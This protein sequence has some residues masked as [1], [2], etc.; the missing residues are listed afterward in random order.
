[1]RVHSNSLFPSNCYDVSLPS[2]KMSCTRYTTVPRT[3]V[4]FISLQ[5]L[6]PPGIPGIEDNAH[7]HVETEKDNE[8]PCTLVTGLISNDRQSNITSIFFIISGDD[9]YNEVIKL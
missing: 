8:L 5:G 7:G 1:M 9:N 4:H 2:I 6:L 3:T